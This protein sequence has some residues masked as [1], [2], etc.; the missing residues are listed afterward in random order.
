[1]E[2]LTG[3]RGRCGCNQSCEQIRDAQRAQWGWS[4]GKPVTTYGWPGTDPLV[5]YRQSRGRQSWLTDISSLHDPTIRINGSGRQL[6]RPV[7]QGLALREILFR[8]RL[9]NDRQLDS[10]TMRL[11]QSVG[12]RGFVTKETRKTGTVH[13]FRTLSHLT[14]RMCRWE[15][16]TEGPTPVK[17][18]LPGRRQTPRVFCSQPFAVCFDY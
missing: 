8:V 4:A 14:Q 1:M 2:E 9:R 6:L 10:K 11:E 3:P 5:S 7:K 16:R 17:Q 18:G 12:A 15:R 13:V